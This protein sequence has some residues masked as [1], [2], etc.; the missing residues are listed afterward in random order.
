MTHVVNYEDIYKYVSEQPR[1][2]N[3]LE[4]FM[5]KGLKKGNSMLFLKLP[6]PNSF[7]FLQIKRRYRIKHSGVSCIRLFYPIPS[8][9]II[10]KLLIIN[11]AGISPTKV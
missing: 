5:I 7:L 11:E 10:A 8:C 2:E 1:S 9:V 4:Q 3:E 6:A